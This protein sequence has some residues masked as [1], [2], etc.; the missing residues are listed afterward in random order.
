MVRRHTDNL[1]TANTT[2]TT[3]TTTTN[4]NKTK[5]NNTTYNSANSQNSPLGLT[6]C[7]CNR[8][9]VYIV[10]TFLSVLANLPTQS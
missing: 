5:N 8:Q 7:R 10:V 9:Y 6:N 4:N 1:A 3:T 2:T